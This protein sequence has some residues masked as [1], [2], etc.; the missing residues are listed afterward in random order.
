[1]RVAAELDTPK[2]ACGGEKPSQLFGAVTG[3]KLT[4]D[5]LWLL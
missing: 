1:M 2:W 3:G 4:R 5:T